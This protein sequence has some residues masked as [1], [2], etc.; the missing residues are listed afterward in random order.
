[1]TSEVVTSDEGRKKMIMIA[2]DVVGLF[3]SMKKKNT[4]IACEKQVMKSP[5]IMKG[6]KY[7]EVARYCA[8]NRKYCGDLSEVENILPWRR[9]TGK[10]GRTPGMQ[11]KEMRGKKAGLEVVWEFPAREA[12]PYQQKVLLS[13]MCRIAVNILW[14][15]F[16][17]T[18]GGEVFLQMEGGPIGARCTMAASR[19]VMQEWS[20]NYLDILIRSGLTVDAIKGYVDD[21]RHW[22]DLL[23]RGTRFN[24][25][26]NKFTWREDWK[27]QDDLEDLPDEVRMAKIFL[28]AMNSVNSDLTFTVETVY[29][30]ANKRL[31]T[32]DLEVEIIMN[33]IVYSYFQ[34]AMKTPLVIG[35]NSAMSDHQKFAILSN[36]MIRRMSNISEKIPLQETVTQK[37]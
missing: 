19:L 17:Y 20:E 33:Q 2:N 32:L 4:G 1:M 30:F 37:L 5:I 24:K 11:S 23:I 35:E 25:A 36:E 13:K 7:R 10:G 22:T 8:G 21:G 26:L 34:K 12:T 9:K 28:V 15:N 3:P 29:D 31:A 18:F 27:Q 6:V 16:M 14:E